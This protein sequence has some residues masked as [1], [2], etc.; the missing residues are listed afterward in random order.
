MRGTRGGVYEEKNSGKQGLLS[1]V[2]LCSASRRRTSNLQPARTSGIL[3][4]GQPE[5]RHHTTPAAVRSPEAPPL[6]RLPQSHHQR[7]LCL[8]K[9]LALAAA[10]AEA[11]VHTSIATHH[12][13]TCPLE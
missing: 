7:L 10:G 3:P 13:I 1:G 9:G 12:A 8:Q 4:E 2:P 5:T 6:A 11:T